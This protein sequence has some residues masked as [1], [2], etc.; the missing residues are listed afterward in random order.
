MNHAVIKDSHGI[1]KDEVNVS[2][3]YS[4][5][6]KYGAPN[7]RAGVDSQD[8]AAAKRVSCA[9]RNRTL[10]KTAGRPLLTAPGLAT[11][12]FLAMGFAVV[13][14]E[15]R[16]SA[17]YRRRNKDRSGV[18]CAPGAAGIVRIKQLRFCWR[19]RSGLHANMRFANGILRDMSGLI[20][21]SP[22]PQRA[23]QPLPVQ[24][25]SHRPSAATVTW[26]LCLRRTGMLRLFIVHRFC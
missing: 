14:L 5:S 15:V 18:K 6:R 9:P 22:R 4:Q 17:E 3:D 2:F 7:A 26:C 20:W 16:F 21:T 25:C 19:L 10:R 8:R 24:S 11:L 12:L 23:R 1:A 13:I